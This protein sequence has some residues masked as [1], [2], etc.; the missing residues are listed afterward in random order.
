MSDE[1]AAVAPRRPDT[2]SREHAIALTFVTLAEALVDDY[3]VVDLL[4][5]LVHG[6]VDLLGASAAGLLLSDQH[7][8]LAVMA[9]SSEESRLLEICQ[10]Q[11]E[12]VPASIAYVPGP[13]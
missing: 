10:L 8:N 5:R 12:K 3:D 7:E 13:R 2:H 11:S 6:C 9:S 1:A 4:D